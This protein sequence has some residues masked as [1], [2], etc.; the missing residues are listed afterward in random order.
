M[1][2]YACNPSPWEAEKQELEEFKVILRY[3]MNSRPART[4]WYPI[5]KE[6]KFN[7]TM[8]C[9]SY[10]KSNSRCAYWYSTC[11]ASSRHPRTLQNSNSKTVVKTIKLYCFLDQ[12]HGNIVVITKV[13]GLFLWL[14]NYDQQTIYF[15]MAIKRVPTFSKNF[16]NW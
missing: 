7:N 9:L 11:L 4:T 6:E 1:G 14:I 13:I 3:I 10:H 16:Y 5:S 15:S 12:G 2:A 8:L